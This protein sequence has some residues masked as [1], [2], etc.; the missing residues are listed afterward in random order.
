MTANASP[1]R[2]ARVCSDTLELSELADADNEAPS[3]SI[4]R[5]MSVALRVFVPFVKTSAVK[6]ARPLLAAGSLLVPESTTSSALIN[7][8]SRFGAT[9]TRMPFAS[10]FSD[11]VG[12]CAD[13]GA[14]G[15]GGFARDASGASVWSGTSVFGSSILR[16]STVAAVAI[17]S[18]FASFGFVSSAR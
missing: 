7:G 3:D 1:A 17:T 9:M 15:A 16:A 8:T 5:A 11:G 4:C 18:P 10:S 14:P 6:P 2:S 13:T 12:S